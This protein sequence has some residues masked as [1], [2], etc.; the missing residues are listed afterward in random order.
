MSGMP[1]RPLPGPAGVGG[2]GLRRSGA[3]GPG[4][5]LDAGSGPTAGSKHSRSVS[6]SS[7][8]RAGGSSGCPGRPQIFGRQ[9]PAA[10]GALSGARPPSCHAGRCSDDVRLRLASRGWQPGPGHVSCLLSS[11]L[12][13]RPLH[14]RIPPLGRALLGQRR[15]ELRVQVLGTAGATLPCGAVGMLWLGCIGDPCGPQ[16]GLRAGHG[17]LGCG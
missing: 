11:Q 3:A 13:M 5:G 16:W 9:Q 4:P 6:V 15:G 8:P 10:L 7:A 2:G 1:P 14:T 12:W 17:G